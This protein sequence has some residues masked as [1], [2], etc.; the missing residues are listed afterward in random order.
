[1][2]SRLNRRRLIAGLCLALF[3]VQLFAASTLGCL[4]DG[5]ADRPAACPFHLAASDGA[6]EMVDDADAYSPASKQAVAESTP[7][8]TDLLDCPK[9]ALH[10]GLHHLRNTP[11]EV[12][13]A[14]P[15]GSEASPSPRLHFYRFV[16]DLII[17][18]PI[19]AD[20]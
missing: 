18:P 20:A 3:Q 12:L 14:L 17:K 10:L 7:A 11:T 4:H 1:M 8:D 16:A 6:D 2:K 5:G 13:A 15:Q 19:P 9:C